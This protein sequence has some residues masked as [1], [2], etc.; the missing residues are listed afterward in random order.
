MNQILRPS[1]ARGAADFGWL[2]SRHSFSFGSYY[3]PDHIGFGALR[4]INE[5][6]VEPSAGF[7]TH[8]HRNMEIISY[9]IS[10]ALEHKDSLG[11]GSVIRPDE[12]QRMTA[13]T[14]VTHSE[15]NHSDD[16]LVHF[17]Q[18]WIVPE[19]DGLEPGY[20]Q[21]TFPQVE[22]TDALR[23]LGSRDARDGSV[24]IHQDVDLY[25]SVLTANKSLTFDIR[26]GRKVW[27]QMVKGRLTANGQTLQAGD[28]LGILDTGP[29][30]LVAGE[31]S[32][33][34]LFDLAA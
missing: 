31:T 22:R 10:G 1:A 29:L 18:I 27:V 9:V 5:D 17:L 28:G 16:D 21:K 20:E 3:D 6:R 26:P 25:G 33:F 19:R 4:V 8:P 2:K 30:D 15:Y 13:G 7:G 32:E 34:L 14:G 12:L 23:L 11:T 24:T